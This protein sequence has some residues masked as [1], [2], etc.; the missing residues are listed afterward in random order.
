MLFEKIFYYLLERKKIE[1]WIFEVNI[2]KPD[3][4]GN[5]N[6][7]GIVTVKPSSSSSFSLVECIDCVRC[8]TLLGYSS[9]NWTICVW[10]P[11]AASVKQFERS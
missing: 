5:G 1:I 3:G 7:L 4:D 6:E 9:N 2:Y 10:P 11:F 8:V